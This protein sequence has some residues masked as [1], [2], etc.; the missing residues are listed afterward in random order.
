MRLIVIL[1][2]VALG[3]VAEPSPRAGPIVGQPT[4]GSVSIASLLSGEL[5]A[6]WPWSPAPNDGDERPREEVSYEGFE[7][8]SQERCQ[9]EQVVDVRDREYDDGGGDQGE[10]N[11]A[12]VARYD[13]FA[14]C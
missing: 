8:R 7:H 1:S 5:G 3:L 9:K 4:F 10:D 2:A 6:R 14:R 12:A 13:L 11:H